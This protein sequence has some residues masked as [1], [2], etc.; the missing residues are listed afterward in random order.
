LERE[1][2][3]RWGDAMNNILFCSMS[4]FKR[5]GRV[6][7]LTAAGLNCGCIADYRNSVTPR[8]TWDFHKIRPDATSKEQAFKECEAL[9]KKRNR[10]VSDS[11]MYG[12]N[13]AGDV[14]TCMKW[15]G[16]GQSTRAVTFE[17]IRRVGP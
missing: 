1:A 6:A 4:W 17:P 5:C 15:E 16:W 11:L 13:F 14:L 3:A 8:F 9:A 10:F 12:Y 7:A 2:L